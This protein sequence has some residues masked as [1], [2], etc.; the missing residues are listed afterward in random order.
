[1]KERVQEKLSNV[2]Q[3]DETRI[4]DHLGELVRDSV[5]ETLNQLLDAEAEQLCNAGR[6]QCTKARL[7]TRADYY[8]GKLQARAGEVTLKI[9]KL[10]QLKFEMGII[11]RYRSMESSQPCVFNDRYRFGKV[12]IYAH[13]SHLVTVDI[14][15]PGRLPASLL[16]YPCLQPD[17]QHPA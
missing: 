16:P 15:I 2:I 7:D 12:P 4:R 10:R 3:I 11:E 14:G 13:A 9:P 17:R 8:E 1:M 6:Y 5:E